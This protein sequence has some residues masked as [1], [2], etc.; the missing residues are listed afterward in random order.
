ME[1]SRERAF[2]FPV[3]LSVAG[4]DNAASIPPMWPDVPRGARLSFQ[5]LHRVRG[6][7]FGST[8]MPGVGGGGSVSLDSLIFLR[9]YFPITSSFLYNFIL[10]YFHSHSQ[11]FV[12]TWLDFTWESG[13]AMGKNISA[14]KGSCAGKLHMDG[15]THISCWF[16][17]QLIHIYHPK[18][19]CLTWTWQGVDR[20]PLRKCWR[21]KRKRVG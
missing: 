21:M 1:L 17:W 7:R 16:P 3:S 11:L 20:V 9:A 5:I 13:S 18:I 6:F 19:L 4:L 15:R 14:D 10:V 2:S 12:P 8:G